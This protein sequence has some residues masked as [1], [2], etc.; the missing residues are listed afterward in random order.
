MPT[1]PYSL[2]NGTLRN[3]LG[4]DDAKALEAAE[5]DITGARLV[6]L[7]QLHLP[8]SY[9]LDHLRA[10]HRYIFGDVYEWAGELRRVDITKFD[11]FCR[12]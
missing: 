3:R 10:F 2:P 12:A 8:G 7:R 6:A 9:D 1:D 5:A 11:T 4:I